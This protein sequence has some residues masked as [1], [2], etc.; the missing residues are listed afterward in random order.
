MTRIPDPAEQPWLPVP[1][2]GRLAFGLGRNASY[3]AAANGQLPA[4]RVGGR[5]VVPTAKLRA[6]LGLDASD[7]A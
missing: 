6:L 1:V 7:A 2:A 3:R 4:V 5:V